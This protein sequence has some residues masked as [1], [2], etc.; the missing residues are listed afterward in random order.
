MKQQEALTRRGRSIAQVQLCDARDRR[1]Q[2]RSVTGKALRGGVGPIRQQSEA[3]VAVGARQMM[4]L[5]A[6]EMLGEHC[7]RRQQRRHDHHRAKLL[8]DAL[9]QLKRGQDLGAKAARD[10]AVHQR[11]GCIERRREAEDR[12]QQ[13]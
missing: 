8:R 11:H 5:E 10:A 13:Q 2:Q 6:L 4:R 1:R 9:A 12:E 3:Q 7:L